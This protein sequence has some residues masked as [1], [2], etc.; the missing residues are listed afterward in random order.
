MR[1]AVIVLYLVA[2]IVNLL[3]G[4]GVLS[5][6]R[7]EAF[8]GV[9]IRSPDLEILMRHRAIVLAIVGGFLAVAAFHAPLRPAALVAGL[10]SMVSFIIIAAA[11]GEYGAPLRRVAVIDL[12]ATV[13]LVLG[14][15]LDRIAGG[16]SDG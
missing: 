15:I 6:A 12:F 8:Y 14:A 1:T 7:M 5:A 4:L 2:A 16:G 13:A 11:V 3:P 10:V 9:P